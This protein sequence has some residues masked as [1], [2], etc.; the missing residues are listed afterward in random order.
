MAQVTVSIAGR[1]YRMAC[2]DGEEAH[3][4]GLAQKI[5]STIESFRGDFGE[6]GDQRLL[7]MAA[8]AVAD[9][10][11]EANRKL[12]VKEAEV[13]ELNAVREQMEAERAEWADSV[14]NA[15][16]TAAQR[17]ERMAKETK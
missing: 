13:A 1:S 9:E 5:D 10:L 2:A 8:V 6:I 17:M 14:A 15:L 16:E 7:V 3:L 11:S 12:A 4:Q